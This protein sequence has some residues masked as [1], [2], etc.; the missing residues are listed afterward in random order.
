MAYTQ[1]NTAFSNDQQPKFGVFCPAGA[2]RKA[3]ENNST[4]VDVIAYETTKY[5]SS[6][7]R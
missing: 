4:Q 1:G 6:E 2:W 5:R 3:Y 7:N